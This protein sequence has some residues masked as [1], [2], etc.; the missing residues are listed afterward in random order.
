MN[1]IVICSLFLKNYPEKLFHGG[2][3]P[4]LEYTLLKVSSV[5]NTGTGRTAELKSTLYCI[6]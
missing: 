4:D 2:K 6:D 1:H 5:A 3:R